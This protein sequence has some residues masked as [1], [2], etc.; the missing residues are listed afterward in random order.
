[1][2]TG[3]S[4]FGELLWPGIRKIWGHTYN[5]WEELYSQFF[6]VEESDKQFEKYQGTTGLGAA[7]IKRE[8][9]SIPY[10]NPNLGFQKIIQHVTYALGSVVTLEMYE[11]DQYNYIMKIPQFLARAMRETEEIVTHGILNNG[12]DNQTGN[13]D[14]VALFS[15][16]HPLVDGSGTYANRPAIAADLT[17]TSLENAEIAISNLVDDKGLKINLKG[18]KLVVP[19]DL[20]FVAHKIQ[21]TQYEVGTDN[22]TVNP[23]NGRHPVI[24]TPYLTDSDGWFLTTTCGDGMKFTNRRSPQ[25]VRENEFDTL[26]LKFANHRR[27]GVGV[28]NPRCVYGSP[29]SD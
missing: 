29:G 24:V 27:F 17:Q 11:D 3:T 13:V 21:N 19:T 15:T 8:G 1:M 28:V 7:G 16:A 18:D 20:Q 2:T 12:F 5:E 23:M 6:E 9:Q 25:I 22:N 10:A 14:Q 4:N 26:N